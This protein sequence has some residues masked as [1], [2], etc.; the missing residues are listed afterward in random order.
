VLVY[1]RRQPG[2]IF[3]L[4]GKS[5]GAELLKSRIDIER[6]PEDDDIHH[7]TECAKLVFLPLAVALARFTP[8]PMK[9]GSP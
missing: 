9:D 2:D 4:H 6:V 8:L 3:R 1:Q 7:E 5:L